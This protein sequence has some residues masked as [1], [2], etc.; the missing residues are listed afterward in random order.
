MKKLFPRPTIRFQGEMQAAPLTTNYALVGTAFD[1]LLRFYIKRMNPKAITDTWI[2][3]IAVQKM[4]IY[5]RVGGFSQTIEKAKKYYKQYLK[6]GKLTPAVIKT[7]IR[8]ARIDPFYRVGYRDPNMNVVHNDD[9][10]DLRNLIKIVDKSIFKAK[11]VCVLNPTFGEASG[12]VRGADADI[13][14]DDTLIEIKTTKHRKI[15]LNTIYQL[16][17]YYLLSRIG[18]I[19]GVKRKV[20]IKYMAVYLARYGIMLKFMVPG[21]KSDFIKISN[22][23]IEAFSKWFI[24]RAERIHQPDMMYRI[25]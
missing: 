6:D 12:Y 8:L 13:L 20:K 23:D 4:D 2:A 24:K 5:D 25:D 7:A 18:G 21:P 17:G 16:I 1:Y 11:K 14:L 3:E 15:H 9:V 10:K 19:D 22:K